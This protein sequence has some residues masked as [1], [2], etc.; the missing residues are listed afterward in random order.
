MHGSRPTGTATLSQRTFE[1]LM[2]FDEARVVTAMQ[3]ISDL[4]G[5]QAGNRSD[6]IAYSE[7]AKPESEYQR[8]MRA[9]AGDTVRNVQ[10]P[11]IN[12]DTVMRL[13][14]IP[15]G[16]NHRD[17]SEQLLERYLTGQRWGQD[18]GSGRLSRRHF[19][20]YRRLHPDI[21]AWT[22]NTKADSVYHYRV[23]RSLSVREFARLQSFPDRFVFTT[24]AR[25]G[26]IAGRHEGGSSHSRYRQVRPRGQRPRSPHDGVPPPR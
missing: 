6:V 24:D 13:K 5:L 15:E 3:A 4:A 11:R 20:A 22:L 10:V 21:W 14:G 25:R 7:I 2:D 9:G 16:G 26:P 19:Y 12:A 17:L 8:L 18:N 1:S 23:A